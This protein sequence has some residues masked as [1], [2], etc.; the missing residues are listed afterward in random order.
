MNALTKE[1]LITSKELANILNVSVR[2]VQKN[3]KSLFPNKGIEEGKKT[4][5]TENESKI[6]LEKLRYNRQGTTATPTLRSI[7]TDFTPAFKLKKANEL[8]K[9]ASLLA[10]EAYEEELSRIK[11]EKEALKIKLDES[12][13]W[14][15]VKRMEKLNPEKKFDWRILKKESEKLGKKIKKVFDAN[16]GEVNSYHFSVWESLYFDSLNYGE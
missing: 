4:Y 8:M 12:K 13:D 14:Y 16:Y 7:T 6:I 1:R 3:G 15:S 2:T 11:Q 10:Q 9:E 5:W